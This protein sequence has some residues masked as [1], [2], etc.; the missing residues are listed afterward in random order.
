VLAFPPSTVMNCVHFTFFD[1]ILGSHVCQAETLP[2]DYLGDGDGSFSSKTNLGHR[3]SENGFYNVRLVVHDD[4]GASDTVEIGVVVLNVA[5]AAMFDWSPSD[6]STL[7][8]MLFRDGSTDPDGS[9]IDVHWGFGDGTSS[10]GVLPTHRNSDDGAYTVSLRIEDD[11]A[12]DTTSRVVHVGN[13]LGF[14]LFE[15]SISSPMSLEN[16]S[17]VDRSSDPDGT[18]VSRNWSFGDGSWSEDVSPVHRYSRPG[19]YFIVLSVEDDDGGVN[20]TQATIRVRNLPPISD[21]D[22]DVESENTAST[23]RFLNIA[24]DLDGSI[25]SYGWTFGDGGLS[26]DPSPNHVF[27]GEGNYD[28]TLTVTDDWGNTSSVTKSVF[29]SLPDLRIGRSGITVYPDGATS[30]RNVTISAVVEN[31]GSRSIHDAQ[32]VFFV[33]GTVIG[34]AL[35]D[36]PSHSMATAN[37]NWT[38]LEGDHELVV[39][40]DSGGTISEI[41]EPNNRVKIS[42]SIAGGQSNP[43]LSDLDLGLVIL[44]VGTIAVAVGIM[45]LS[46]IKG[47]SGK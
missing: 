20:S 29:V 46:R 37:V 39:E 45:L 30:G 12:S 23:I 17:F 34:S 19:D 18:I 10:E 44:L 32:V 13:S 24:S 7:S 41:S 21:F 2:D 35:I 3:Y 8:I 26:D 27:Q 22:W 16:V 33:D 15:M 47:K 5:P 38:V 11:G 40:V 6:P 36:I 42:V 43:L 25:A 31:N 1:E 28:V 4:V 9:I 14:A